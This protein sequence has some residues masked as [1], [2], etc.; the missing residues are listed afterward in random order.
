MVPGVALSLPGIEA[1][2]STAKAIEDSIW[3]AYLKGRAQCGVM[4]PRPVLDEPRRRMIRGRLAGGFTPDDLRA[5]AR[6]IWLSSW[7]VNEKRT[8]FELCMRSAECVERCRGYALDPDDSD[9]LPPPKIDESKR[10]YRSA[11]TRP[12]RTAETEAAE[13]A[14]LV[15]RYPDLAAQPEGAAANG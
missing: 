10:V 14:A 8:G 4:G 15:S 6:G 9:E 1:P 13:L 12:R 5:A 2:P 7:H 11:P 3:A